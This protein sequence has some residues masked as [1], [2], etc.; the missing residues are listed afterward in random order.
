[1][2]DWRA[3]LEAL[4]NPDRTPIAPQYVA[5]LIDDLAPALPYAIAMQ[6]A[7]PGRQ[8]IAYLGDGGFAMLMAD[9]AAWARACGGYG[10]KVDKPGE[11]PDALRAALAYEGPALVDVD[12]DPHEPPRHDPRPSRPTRPRSDT[13]PPAKPAAPTRPDTDPS[14]R[15]A[16]EPR[17]GAGRGRLSRVRLSVPGRPARNGGTS[18]RRRG[19]VR[20]GRRGFRTRR[21]RS[22][23]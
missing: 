4:E 19:S 14:T 3:Q 11:L 5:G 9:F 23:R 12:V 20:A 21:R 15:P 8:V 18:R 2:T 6:Y 22:G 17:R 7:F 13:G 10:A 16:A 1:M